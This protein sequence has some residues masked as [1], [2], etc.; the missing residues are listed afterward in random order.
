M[1]KALIIHT[2]SFFILLIC[3][4]SLHAQV[5]QWLEQSHGNND[6]YTI[7]SVTDAAG[8]TYMVS[9][10]DGVHITFGSFTLNN[11]AAS[12]N[13]PTSF[14][15]KYDA[16]GNVL[17]AKLLGTFN[18]AYSITMDAANNLYVYGNF[19]G[20]TTSFGSFM[21]TNASGYDN[22]LIKL[23]SSGN[24]IWAISE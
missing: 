13:G 19:F 11:P 15:V 2:F 8:N 5:C 10:F 21:L 7:G 17:W 18:T 6:D 12:F 14:L 16:S 4:T 23:D 20:P 9:S 22:F 24:A 1:K 3:S